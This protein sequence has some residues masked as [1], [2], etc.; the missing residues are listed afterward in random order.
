MH[1]MESMHTLHVLFGVLHLIS[2]HCG[3]VYSIMQVHPL[4]E[5]LFLDWW[6]ETTSLVPNLVVVFYYQE[7]RH[8]LL[9]SCCWLSLTCKWVPTLHSGFTL[10]GQNHTVNPGMDNLIFV[11]PLVS[12][13]LVGQSSLCMYELTLSHDGPSTSSWCHLGGSCSRLKLV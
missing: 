2:I 7:C 8:D 1:C 4:Q 3:I 5:K 9:V 12:D 10:P 11:R 13:D 6:G